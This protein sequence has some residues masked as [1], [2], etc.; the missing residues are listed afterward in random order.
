VNCEVIAVGTELLLGQIVDTN[1]SWIG[2]RLA[3]AGIDSHY[4]TKVGDNLDR[5]VSVLRIALERSDAVIMCGGLGPTQDDITREAIAQVMGVPLVRH[6]DIVEVIR[7]MF[8]RRGREMADS[9]LRQADVPEGATVIPQ[10]IGT[11]PGLICP[12]GPNGERV[13]YAVPG[14]P[15]EMEEMMDR[16]VVPDLQERSGDRSVIL[17]RTIRTW[18]LAESTLAETVQPRLDELDRRGN[19]TIAFLASGMEGIKVRITVKAADEA[20]AQQLLDEEE[21]ELRAMLGD[22][23]FGTDSVSMEQAVGRLL[24]DQGLTLA[25]AESL[26]GGMVGSRLTNAVGSS[27]WFRGAIVAYD[28]QVKFDLLDVPEGPV[29]SEDAARAMAAGVRKVLGADV[30]LSTTGVAGPTEQDGMPVGT[31]FLGMAIGDHVEALETRLPG[32]R[33]RVRQFATISVLNLL[34]LRLLEATRN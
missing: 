31:V 34:R 32:D 19:P 13:V 5:I 3:T 20:N 29:V 8:G 12:V 2:E 22:I 14:V 21:D 11:A 1:S 9:N 24:A 27:E 25:V 16:A 15:Y 23:V 17:S 7:E 18:G 26:T 33:D 30:G 4:Q 6:D 28:S 10:R